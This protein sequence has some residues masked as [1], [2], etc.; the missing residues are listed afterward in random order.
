MKVPWAPIWIFHATLKS[1]MARRAGATAGEDLPTEGKH[2][3]R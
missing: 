3:Q 2:V 1:E